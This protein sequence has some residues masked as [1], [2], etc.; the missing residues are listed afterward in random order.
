MFAEQMMAGAPGVIND[1]EP[2]L[3][4][5]PHHLCSPPPYHLA[6]SAL[7]PF[8]TSQSPRPTTSPP[9]YIYAPPPCNLSSASSPYRLTSP[10]SHH[11]S[12]QLPHLPNTWTRS[13]LT[14]S[15]PQSQKRQMRALCVSEYT[16]DDIKVKVIDMVLLFDLDL[17]KVLYG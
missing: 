1:A 11:L 17:W 10:P 9:R 15:P 7:H 3:S 6:T 5:A 4:P 13:Q 14:K 16:Q 2:R 8:T 12:T